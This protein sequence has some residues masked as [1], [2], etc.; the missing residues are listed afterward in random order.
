MYSVVSDKPEGPWSM[1][2]KVNNPSQLS[3]GLGYDNSI[4]ID[5]DGKWYLVVKNG[6][7][8]NGIVEL[9]KT[10]QPTGIVYDLSW[11][12]PESA[13]HPYSWAEGP[14][15]WKHGG[16][17]YYAFARDVSGGQKVMRSKTL[18]ADKS[19]WTIPVDM[20]DEKDPKKGKSIFFAPNHCSSVVELSDGTSWLLHPVWARANNNEWYGQ[21]RQGLLN[22]VRYD[23]DNNV[24]A[25]YPVNMV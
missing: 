16:Y 22:Q 11:L 15:M 2:A 7:S 17:Y 25:D 19:A 8:N 23:A 9:D 24:M 14:V 13:N 3:Y 20:F 18:T 5:D 6:Q 12:N 1:P 21:G 10:G 4:F